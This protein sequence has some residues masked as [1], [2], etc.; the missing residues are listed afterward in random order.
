[1]RFNLK[2]TRTLHQK[3]KRSF[4]FFTPISACLMTRG[5][6]EALEASPFASLGRDCNLSPRICSPYTK[7]RRFTGGAKYQLK[8][9]IFLVF[10]PTG[11]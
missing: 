1:M 3:H 8:K 2:T 7:K 11:M 9:T 10:L 4:L 5:T 6:R